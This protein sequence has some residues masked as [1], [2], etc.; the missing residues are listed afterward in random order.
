M[1]N[2][3]FL[4][5]LINFTGAVHVN[6][7]SYLCCACTNEICFYSVHSKKNRQKFVWN[8]TK[9]HTFQNWTNFCSKSNKKISSRNRTKICLKSNK[10]Y[11]KNPFDFPLKI[12]LV[13]NNF[14][15][16][17]EMCAFLFEFALI[18]VQFFIL[19]CSNLNENT[20][21]YIF[22]IKFLLNLYQRKYTNFRNNKITTSLS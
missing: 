13:S 10:F 22:F 16:I 18:F 14:L 20:F 6:F 5:F 11:T 2:L 1:S 9:T 4:T 17:F 3:V 8:Q 12:C 7:G 21:S 15:F 19:F